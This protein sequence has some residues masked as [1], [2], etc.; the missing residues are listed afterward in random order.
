M[1]TSQSATDSVPEAGKAT[2]EPNE[3]A[4]S[5]ITDLRPQALAVIK[6]A[7]DEGSI[8]AALGVLALPQTKP[9][10]SRRQRLLLGGAAATAAIV[11]L[12]AVIGYNSLN[13]GQ[14]GDNAPPPLALSPLTE[15]STPQPQQVAETAP[16]ETLPPSD[17]SAPPTA[18][19]L[20]T[21]VTALPLSIPT[22]GTASGSKPATNPALKTLPG[23]GANGVPAAPAGAGVSPTQSP[24]QSGTGSPAPAAPAP[25]TPAAGALDG[26][27]KSAQGSLA[28]YRISKQ[29]ITGQTDVVVGRTQGIRASINIAGDSLT[30]TKVI[31]DMNTVESGEVLRDLAFR[32]DLLQTTAFP[33]AVFELTSPIPLQ[34]RPAPGGVFTTRANGRLTLHGVAKD[35]VVDLQAQQDGAV[36]KVVGTIP[37]L[38]PDFNLSGP[39]IG[40]AKVAND[41]TIEFSLVF[42]RQ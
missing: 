6:N 13:G 34:G 3:L 20:G 1:D 5:E 27:W 25:A 37:V 9:P 33:E 30:A 14:S 4:A 42:Q 39:D 23:A 15:A 19:V 26:A 12:G 11:L 31:V 22:S 2:K 28:G 7:L 38:L 35:L 18:E 16:G 24:V 8:E 29:W 36:L 41:G 17:N 40:L 10:R 32:N 21:S